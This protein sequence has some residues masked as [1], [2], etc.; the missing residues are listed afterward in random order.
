M[1]SLPNTKLSLKEYQKILK[2]SKKSGSEGFFHYSKADPTAYKIFS[3]ANLEK[4]MSESKERKLALLYQKQLDDCTMPIC[5]LSVNGILVGY[6]LTYDVDDEPFRPTY[7]SFSRRIHYL[8][9]SKKVLE[10][11]ANQDIIYGDVAERNILINRRNGK[12][13]FC[14]MD[15]ISINGYPIDSIPDDLANYH[16]IRKIDQNT[17]TYM[18]NIMCLHAFDIDLYHYYDDDFDFF[19]EPPA[20]EIVKRMLDVKS[21]NGESIVQY[22]KKRR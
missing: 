9:Q 17:D 4:C 7:L 21:Y 11:F 10:N 6:E 18:H 3:N 12:L 22:I 15:N 5:T 2:L 8:E 20:E 16:S 19:Y 1:R 13:K 14:D